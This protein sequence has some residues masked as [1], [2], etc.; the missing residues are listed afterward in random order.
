MN[1]TFVI[2]KEKVYRQIFATSAHTTRAREA[3]G[4][5]QEIT[6]RMLLTADNKHIIAPLIDNSINDVYAEI[7]R[8]HPDCSVN[9]TRNGEG[10]GCYVFNM[11]IPSN[12]PTDN[13]NQLEQRVE[14]YIVN[15]TL[16]NWYSNVKP[17]EASI[18]ATKR[19]ND[20]AIIQMLLTRRTKPLN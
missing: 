10:D 9:F 6:E 4:L 17:D 3:I 12:Y 16:Q 5:P 15:S 7:V 1:V 2:T 14:S 18:I 20:A 8:Y 13:I 19:Q 11:N